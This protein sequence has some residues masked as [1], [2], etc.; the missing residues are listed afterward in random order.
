MIIAAGRLRCHFMLV[1]CGHQSLSSRCVTFSFD[2]S[3][4]INVVHRL[5]G[6]GPRMACY[7]ALV[8][9]CLFYF[10]LPTPWFASCC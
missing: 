7:P 6:V 4:Y 3:V 8:G 9:L 10:T 5:Y 1:S 2:L